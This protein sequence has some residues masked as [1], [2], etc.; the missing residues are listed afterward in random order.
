MVASPKNV[1]FPIPGTR[2][3]ERLEEN[4][5]AANNELTPEKLC[6]IRAVEGA[7]LQLL[8]DYLH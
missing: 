8:D 2:K 1:D 3:M 4:I 6:D 7:K 5:G